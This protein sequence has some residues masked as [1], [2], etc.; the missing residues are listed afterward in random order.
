MSSRLYC[1]NSTFDNYPLSL[2]FRFLF[3]LFLFSPFTCK[4]SVPWIQ[5]NLSFSFDL[6]HLHLC[7]PWMVPVDSNH[8]WM[9]EHNPL[10]PIVVP[11]HVYGAP[12]DG[13]NRTGAKAGLG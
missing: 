9:A 7:K 3:V 13:E 5:N 10:D 4:F 12:H 6:G 11:V 8:S 1:F 2:P